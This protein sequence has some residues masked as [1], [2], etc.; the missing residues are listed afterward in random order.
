M[1]FAPLFRRKKRSRLRAFVQRG[2]AGCA[3]Q[4]EAMCANSLIIIK[5]VI[6]VIVEVVV[7]ILVVIVE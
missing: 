5:K 7:V 1:A 4:R 2:C 3:G 6:V